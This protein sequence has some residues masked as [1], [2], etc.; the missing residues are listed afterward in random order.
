MKQIEVLHNLLTYLQKRGTRSWKQSLSEAIRSFAN[1]DYLDFDSIVDEMAKQWSDSASTNE[2]L[3]NSFGIDFTNADNGSI[4]GSDAGG[5][6]PYNDVSLVEEDGVYND[7]VYPQSNTSVTY[8]GKITI[9]YGNMASLSPQSKFIAGLLNTWWMDSC[10]SR[11]SQLFDLSDDPLYN[12]PLEFEYD[13][14]TGFLAAVSTSGVLG[15]EKPSQLTLMYNTYYTNGVDL[16]DVNGYLPEHP[17][18][19]LDVTTL[20]ELTHMVH[21]IEIP[22]CSFDYPVW[23]HE[24]LATVVEGGDFR[25]SA[26]YRFF[27]SESPATLAQCFNKTERNQF[28]DPEGSYV[29]G[30]LFFRFVARLFADEQEKPE[31]QQG[32]FKFFD[33]GDKLVGK[34]TAYNLHE[35]GRRFIDF[36][37]L[38]GEHIQPWELLQDKFET[39]IGATFRVPIK[40]YRSADRNQNSVDTSQLPDGV[41]LGDSVGNDSDTPCFYVSLQYQKVTKSTYTSYIQNY[42][43]VRTPEL[44]Y[45]DG[46]ETESR[47]YTINTE[48]NRH[49]SGVN[50]PTSVDAMKIRNIQRLDYFCQTGEFI[51]VSPHTLF[52]DNLWMCE[53]G[54]NACLPLGTSSDVIGL[55]RYLRD[56]YGCTGQGSTQLVKPAIF[57]GTGVP[58]LT[59][60]D[61]NL[62]EYAKAS[63]S[64]HYWF[65]KTD[66]S[67][68][69]TFKLSNGSSD[70]VYQ[71]LSFGMLDSLHE[72]SYMFPLF[73]AGGK[74]PIELDMYSWQ[75]INMVCPAVE[76]GTAYSLD[77]K[78][79]EF[80][81]TNLLH[82]TQCYNCKMTNFRVM[83]PQGL[84]KY[85]TTHHQSATIK[86]FYRCI[87]GGVLCDPVAWGAIVHEP[88]DV[89]DN[90]HTLYPR[91]GLDSRNMI[92]TYTV[93]KEFNRFEFSSPL[94]PVMPFLDGK[95]DYDETGCLGIVPN[96]YASFFADL[97]CGE[98][99][100]GGKAYLSI[101]CGWDKRL[102]E[103]PSRMGTIVNE[104]DGLV[105]VE[106][107]WSD[108]VNP[109][110]HFTINDRI[111]IP[112]DRGN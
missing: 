60:S 38:G 39:F 101:P 42:G 97:P 82:P 21:N 105:N 111:L 22:Y 47:Y 51:A 75:G 7:I 18:M 8:G 77:V 50:M 63:N 25:K 100:I 36:A 41:V 31:E 1:P 57:P 81:N 19:L 3:L 53:Q 35:L 107:R 16:H 65:V 64:I 66:Y 72:E 24:G 89:K 68:I 102:W 88:T 23:F 73:V 52:D 2:F 43:D 59:I 62:N 61:D 33:L 29:L 9:H 56:V 80:F 85:I 58:W 94:L 40:K 93:K 12:V 17:T 46:D 14:S 69:I 95:L 103:Y 112:I 92:D 91:I 110:K 90:A 84:W 54:G 11:F 26:I 74:T 20:H 87:C 48:L 10:V 45:G 30:F 106:K 55:R 32:D 78:N 5:S 83:S 79:P 96:V 76:Y 49:Y 44:F 27:A 86:G 13:T 34:G 98:I 104:E 109:L 108:R 71:T 99:M 37:Q 4:F 28:A 70:S 15:A 67:A 6:I